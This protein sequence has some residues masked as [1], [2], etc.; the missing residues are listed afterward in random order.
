MSGMILAPDFIGSEGEHTN[1]S[2]NPVVDCFVS[3]K[4]AM[5]AIVLNAKKT[6]Q[7]KSCGY[8]EEQGEKIA[9][10]VKINSTQPDKNKWNG[11]DND[12]NHTSEV[13][14]FFV[15][16]ENLSPFFCGFFLAGCFGFHRVNLFYFKGKRNHLLWF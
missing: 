7:E 16:S 13:I 8:D 5:S 11:S 6:D 14:G 3:K 15:V 4:G 1:N 9:V 10:F 2:S 12:F